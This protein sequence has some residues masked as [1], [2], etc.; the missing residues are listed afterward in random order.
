MMAKTQND[1]TPADETDDAPS[2]S[3][4]ADDLE[5]LQSELDAYSQIVAELETRIDEKNQTITQLEDRMDALE[6]ENRQLRHDLD[7]QREKRD[8]LQAAQQADQMD[9]DLRAA[10]CVQNLLAKADSTGRQRVSMD[11]SDGMEALN[12]SIHRTSV[13]DVYE[14]AEKLVGDT[15]VLWFKREPRSSKKNSRLILDR[16]N[17]NLPRML[18]GVELHNTSNRCGGSTTPQQGA[19]GREAATDGGDTNNQ[20]RNS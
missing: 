17:G 18:A 9:Q 3:E 11:N 14:K 2:R 12:H 7:E 13:Y 4:L 8:W 1:P 19:G 10:L 5:R 16:T 15:D 20:T 6:R